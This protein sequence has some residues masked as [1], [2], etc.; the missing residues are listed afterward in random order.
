M[1]T[2]SKFRLLV[3]R[4][5]AM[6]D[7]LHALP[8]VTALRRSHPSWVIDWVVESRWKALLAAESLAGPHPT[9]RNPG[10]PLVDTIHLATTKQWRNRALSVQTLQE[11]RTLRRDLRA[12]D[13]DAVL[14]LQGAIRSALVCRLAGCRRVIGEA[15]PR[16]S[17]ARLF[18]TEQ[19]V[20]CGAHVIE[21]DVELAAA[22]AGDEL[23]TTLPML[24]ID[25]A[26]EDWAEQILPAVSGQKAVLINPGAGWG[27]KR[28]PVERYAAVAVGLIGRGFRVVVNAGPGEE[29]LADAIE[30]SAGS[31]TRINCSLGQL[32]ALTRR[33]ALVIAGDTGPLHLACALGRPVVGIYGPT[34]P[35][36]NGP[37]GTRFKVLRSPE[38]RRDHTRREAP[39]AGLLTIQPDDVLTAADELL[40]PEITR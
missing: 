7:I 12:G 30:A 22:V 38:S 13:Y 33:V 28:W 6:G 19:V 4:L 5:G 15:N 8:A 27:A 35:S 39:E 20:T 21:Q 3:V 17:I 9:Q 34:D 37:Y 40:A 1:H 10:Q 29:A 23:E 26:A 14:D 24:P 25:P 2:Q 18:F 32:I 36:R 11:I 31:A 16:E